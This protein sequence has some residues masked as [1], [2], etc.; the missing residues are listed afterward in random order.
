M[1]PDSFIPAILNTGHC[2]PTIVQGLIFIKLVPGRSRAAPRLHCRGR[3]RLICRHPDRRARAGA[4]LQGVVG[5]ALL[6]AAGLYAMTNLGMMPGGGTALSL[7]TG[8]LAV[9]IGVHFVLGAL[10]AFG[11]GMYAPSLITLSLLGLNPI[12]AFPIMMGSCAFLMSPLRHALPA[13]GAHRPPRRNRH[14]AWRN[15]ARAGRSL[16]G[17]VAAA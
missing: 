2:L 6:I 14:R 17:E 11:I 13:D 10:M 5:I 16:P 15:S 8:P 3:G 4:I 9:A 12:A 7:G 1:V